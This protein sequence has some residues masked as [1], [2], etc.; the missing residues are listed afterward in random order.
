MFRLLANWLTLTNLTLGVILCTTCPGA[1]LTNLLISAAVLCDAF[2]GVCAR[3]SRNHTNSRSGRILDSIADSVTFCL[4]PTLLLLRYIETTHLHQTPLIFLPVMYFLFAFLREFTVSKKDHVFIGLP[5]TLVAYA[6]IIYLNDTPSLSLW[7]V[8]LPALGM[9]LRLHLPAL[10]HIEQRLSSSLLYVALP[11]A[12]IGAWQLPVA[13]LLILNAIVLAY[14]ARLFVVRSVTLCSIAMLALYSNGLDLE[15]KFER[16]WPRAVYSFYVKDTFMLVLLALRILYEHSSILIVVG[17]NLGGRYLRALL[18]CLGYSV[19]TV[20]NKNPHSWRPIL[21][22]CHA[23]D[24]IV[25]SADGPAGPYEASKQ[26]ALC[27]AKRSGCAALGLRFSPRKCI[28]LASRRGTIRVPLP[29]SR[30]SFST[31]PSIGVHNNVASRT[32]R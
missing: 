6:T 28:A 17:D 25:V 10:S 20:R 32:D 13:L 2:D 23:Y 19:A 22:R 18:E 26:G 1:L 21:R 11:V 8:V 12:M 3:H 27:L 5:N 9:R 31:V 14:L 15:P 16:S 7:L 24:Y 29:F 4:F 30:L